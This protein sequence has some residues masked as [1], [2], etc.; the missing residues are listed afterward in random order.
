M[1]A[2]TDMGNILPLF[3]RQTMRYFVRYLAQRLLDTVQDDSRV[4]DGTSEAEGAHI[5]AAAAS[6]PSDDELTG[7]VVI[8][9]PDG[10]TPV[11]SEPLHSFFGPGT[12][13]QQCKQL[14][15]TAAAAAEYS[16]AQDSA[17]SVSP[18]LDA[19]HYL[20]SNNTLFQCNA[21][22]YYHP[23]FNLESHYACMP[24]NNW[25]M[26]DDTAAASEHALCP[27][28]CGCNAKRRT[29]RIRGGKRVKKKPFSYRG[30][31]KHQNYL[32]GVYGKNHQ[33]SHRDA[34]AIPCEAPRKSM[35]H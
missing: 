13:Q 25:C 15:G 29:R 30:G 31:G 9:G 16:A 6:S 27:S 19:T 12:Q 14:P 1:L 17:C 3:R 35:H 23:T 2:A 10:Y 8:H 18:Y 28:P 34:S 7:L 22:P 5:S 24:N 26:G 20:N 32:N 11:R 4:A 21:S 33:R